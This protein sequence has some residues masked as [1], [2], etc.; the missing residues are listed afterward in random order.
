MKGWA[1]VNDDGLKGNG[2]KKWFDLSFDFVKSLPP[3]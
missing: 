3:K 2:L 1:L